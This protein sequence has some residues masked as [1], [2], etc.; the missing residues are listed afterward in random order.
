MLAAGEGDQ[1]CRFAAVDGDG[2][3]AGALVALRGYTQC[4]ELGSSPG[5]FSFLAPAAG[6]LDLV[7]VATRASTSLEPLVRPMPPYFIGHRLVLPDE[8]FLL[9]PLSAGDGGEAVATIEHRDASGRLLAPPA[10]LGQGAAGSVDFLSVRLARAG[11]SVLASFVSGLPG[12]RPS[13]YVQPL[14]LQGMPLAP[15]SSLTDVGF[16]FG[17]DGSPSG[18]VIVTGSGTDPSWQTGLLLLELDARGVPRGPATRIGLYNQIYKAH[19]LVGDDGD[20]ALLVYSGDPHG[21]DGIGVY[22]RPLACSAH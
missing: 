6:A 4:D 16:A 3:P 2:N 14:T 20:H 9:P 17:A 8:S 15:A 11:A 19:V 1:T 7:A 12:A 18:D 22:A 5:G 13:L 21:G 10:T